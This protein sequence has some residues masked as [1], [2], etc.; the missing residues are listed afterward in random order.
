[1]SEELRGSSIGEGVSVL[2]RYQGELE[3][4]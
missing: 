2:H 3:T 4:K 1:V